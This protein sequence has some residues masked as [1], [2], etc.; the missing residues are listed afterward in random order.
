MFCLSLQ[1]NFETIKMIEPLFKHCHNILSNWPLKF[2]FIFLDGQLEGLM[3]HH[4]SVYYG[5][6]EWIGVFTKKNGIAHFDRGAAKGTTKYFSST[7]TVCVIRCVLFYWIYHELD[8]R[9]VYLWLFTSQQS[10]DYAYTYPLYF[11]LPQ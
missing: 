7:F 11:V 10:I 9:Y 6:S 3:K 4:T 5:F 1:F 8:S 2:V